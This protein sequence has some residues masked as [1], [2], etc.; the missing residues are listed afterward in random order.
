[1]NEKINTKHDAATAILK[2][3]M[4]DFFDDELN[5]GLINLCTSDGFSIHSLS[6]SDYA[7]EADK[8]AAIASTLCSISDVSAEQI[9]KGGFN[10]ATVESINGAIL[11][12]KTQFLDLQSVLCVATSGKMSLGEARYYCQRMANEI[13]AIEA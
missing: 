11:F 3:K 2:G 7:V 6:R 12:L 9:S 8:V 10:I 1:M 5:I 13:E 4:A